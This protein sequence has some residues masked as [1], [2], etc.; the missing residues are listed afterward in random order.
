MGKEG[1]PLGGTDGP[2]A[3]L[4]AWVGPGLSL[5]VFCRWI[6]SDVTPGTWV[7]LSTPDHGGSHPQRLLSAV[8]L[9]TLTASR[10]PQGCRSHGTPGEKGP[11]RER[12]PGA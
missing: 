5:V 3:Q 12:D 11:L 6:Q 10:S 8:D 1:R 4:W 2:E 9:Y 7:L